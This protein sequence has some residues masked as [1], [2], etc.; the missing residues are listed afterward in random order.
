MT[1]H[2]NKWIT[3]V[4]NWGS[5]LLGTPL[6]T[7]LGGVSAQSEEAREFTHHVPSLTVEQRPGDISSS[8]LAGCPSGREH[9]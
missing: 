1:E 8:P 2:M 4:D 5:A 3:S 9:S 6:W 7:C